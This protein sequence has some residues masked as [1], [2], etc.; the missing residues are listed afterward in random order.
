MVRFLLLTRGDGRKSGK[1]PDHT[2]PNVWVPCNENPEELISKS[3]CCPTSFGPMGG[4]HGFEST[5]FG[6]GWQFLYFSCYNYVD[7]VPLI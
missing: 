4:G 7:T 6:V 1:K 5:T 2:P 3:Q